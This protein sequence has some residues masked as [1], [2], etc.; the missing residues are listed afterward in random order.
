MVTPLIYFSASALSLVLLA[1]LYLYEDAR[2][3]RIIFPRLRAH[4]DN[5]CVVVILF[6]IKIVRM[7]WHGIMQFVLRHG[8]YAF[9]GATV[10]FLRRL[11]KRVEY[12][13]LYNRH[14]ASKVR[15]NRERTHLD[16][17]AEHKELTALSEEDRQRLKS[18]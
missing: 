2:G 3:R 12:A 18:E 16:E 17:I 7:L 6:L 15:Q 13:V 10:T 5:A 4:L 11:E 1:A 9:L 8:V 14:A